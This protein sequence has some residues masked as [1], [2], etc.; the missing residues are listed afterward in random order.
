MKLPRVGA[1]YRQSDTA[2]VGA[3]YLQTMHIPLSA[4][5][6]FRSS[7]MHSPQ[8]VAVVTR[9][10]AER[11]FGHYNPLG[12]HFSSDGKAPRTEIISVCNNT[13][14]IPLRDPPPPVFFTLY[15]QQDAME[16]ATYLIRS[17]AAARHAHPVP[18]PRRRSD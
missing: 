11:F 6:T 4:G 8:K 17:I 7:D 14:Y 16:R 13:Y 2:A 10:F 1:A 18:A 5:R 12:Q 3:D 9:A 15:T